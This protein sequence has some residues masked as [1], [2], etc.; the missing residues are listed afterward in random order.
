MLASGAS[1]AGL[2]P[3]GERMAVAIIMYV[4]GIVIMMGAD[5]QK[6]FTL[7]I[8]KGLITT[9][10]NSITRNPNYLGEIMLYA[11]FNIVAQVQTTWF[12][13]LFVWIVVFNTRMM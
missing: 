1:P 8:K 4:F 10:F 5:G 13:Y 7:A 6:T 2:E 12:H 9:G 11:S 3:S